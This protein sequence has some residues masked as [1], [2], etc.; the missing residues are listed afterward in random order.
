[1]RKGAIG[2]FFTVS[3]ELQAVRQQ[4]PLVPSFSPLIKGFKDYAL[5]VV[6]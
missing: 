1:M 4:V 6:T 2:P 3:T 5:V